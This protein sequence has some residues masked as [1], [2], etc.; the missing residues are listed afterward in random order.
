M[1][2]NDIILLVYSEEKIINVLV[3]IRVLAFFLRV[4]ILKEDGRII[5]FL[6]SL[7]SRE[8]SHFIK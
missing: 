2:A 3:I 5:N 4:S 8:K 1:R 6:E 7:L